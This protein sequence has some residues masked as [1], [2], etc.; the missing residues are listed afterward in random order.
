M[1]F[2]LPLQTCKLY[3][4]LSDMAIA[5]TPASVRDIIFFIIVT[6][7]KQ[8]PNKQC[9]L[10]F[11]R[12]LVLLLISRYPVHWY[13]PPKIMITDH[14][15]LKIQVSQDAET[16]STYSPPTLTSALAL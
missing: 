1:A 10:P 8:A 4:T 14:A 9:F 3:C 11:L 6:S 15:K 16:H 7:I 13:H 2:Q 5:I 12:K